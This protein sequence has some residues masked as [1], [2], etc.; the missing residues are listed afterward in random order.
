[1]TLQ[2]QVSGCKRTRQLGH[3]MCATCW[4]RVP[5][6]LRRDVW[7]TLAKLR[8]S[9]GSDHARQRYG[10]AVKAALSAVEQ[11]HT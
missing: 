7:W 5:L 3:L 6:Q 9:V 1:M 8:R 10:E 2:C 11:A 4:Y